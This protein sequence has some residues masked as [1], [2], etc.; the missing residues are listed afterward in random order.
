MLLSSISW[1]PKD[2]LAGDRNYSRN[3]RCRSHSDRF[4][5]TNVFDTSPSGQFL[6]QT[7]SSWIWTTATRQPYR[8]RTIMA[9]SVIV[10]LFG[11]LKTPL[12]RVHHFCTPCNEFLALEHVLLHCMCLAKIRERCQCSLRTLFK[13]TCLETFLHSWRRDTRSSTSCKKTKSY[14]FWLCCVR[15]LACDFMTRLFTRT[16]LVLRCVDNVCFEV[17]LC[18][19]S[20]TPFLFVLLKSIRTSTFRGNSVLQVFCVGH[21]K[22]SFSDFQQYLHC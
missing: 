21:L 7:V 11:M 3:G 9:S 20:N 15:F 5:N 16:W 14:I 8:V 22:I 1:T 17:T 19:K 13:N 10:W 18:W 6:P 4:P 2:G 12:M